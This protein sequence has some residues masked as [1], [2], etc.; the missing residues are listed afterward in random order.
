MR[1]ITDTS[2]PSQVI[3]DLEWTLTSP[4]LIATPEPV[5]NTADSL[6]AETLN[7]YHAEL[8]SF[9][10][11]QNSHRNDHR[12]GRYFEQLV[13]FYLQRIRR[14][15]MVASGLQIH[16]QGRTIGELDF[17]F[18]DES[19]QLQHWETAVKFY[20]CFPGSA[21]PGQNLIGPDPRDNFSSKFNRLFNHQLPLSEK[22]FS[23]IA[24]RHAFVKGQIF[25]H[26]ELSPPPSPCSQLCANHLR[27]V[28]LFCHELNWLHRLTEMHGD[29]TAQ[30]M[31]KPYWLSPRFVP[32]SPE[33]CPSQPP[34]TVRG[35]QDTLHRH[36]QKSSRPRLIS[37]LARNTGQW[38]EVERVFVVS[39]SWPNV[40][41]VHT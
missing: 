22:R 5:D 3:Q 32:D 38:Y 29:V 20:L 33:P 19:G 1:S 21:E 24:A 26:P 25:Y 31:E 40:S 36:F 2:I 30:V 4:G 17:V 6:T 34:L 39:E 10:E 27:G 11:L 23:E 13:L 41:P 37:L 8:C 12:V 14:V 35:I 16:E 7:P 28:W 15:D 9:L 18:R